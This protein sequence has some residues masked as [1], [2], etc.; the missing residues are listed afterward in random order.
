MDTMGP[1][2]KTRSRERERINKEEIRGISLDPAPFFSPSHPFHICI[3]LVQQREVALNETQL[4]R[5]ENTS[6]KLKYSACHPPF[7]LPIPQELAPLRI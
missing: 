1:I 6:D 4:G 3:W 7:T 2:R 5:E